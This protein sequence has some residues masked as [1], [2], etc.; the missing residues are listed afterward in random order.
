M[1]KDLKRIKEELQQAEQNFNYA[2]QEYLDAAIY[3][4]N[5]VNQKFKAMLREKKKERRI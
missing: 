2:G 1:D 4:M 3:E 5:A